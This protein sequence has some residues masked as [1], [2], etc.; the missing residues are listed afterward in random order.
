M[1]IK[2]L[3]FS[4]ADVVNSADVGMVQRGSGFRLTPKSFQSLAVLGYVFWKELES[5]KP[6]EARVL[7]F[8]HHVHTAATE[9]LD[10]AIVRDGLVNQVWEFRHC[11]EMLGASQNQVNQAK[12]LMMFREDEVLLRVVGKQETD[13]PFR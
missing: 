4:L 8:V 10:D 6:V 1:A 5:N 2:A 13:N 3:P 7:C 12:P 11:A 9:P